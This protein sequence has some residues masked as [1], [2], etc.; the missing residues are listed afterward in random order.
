MREIYRAIKDF[1]TRF[2]Q[3]HNLSLNEGMLLCNLNGRNHTSSEIADILDLS[4]SNT[5]KVIK[6]VEDKGLIERSLGKDDKRQM[7]FSLTPEGRKRLKN[8]QCEC[9]DGT[10][11]DILKSI[12]INKTSSINH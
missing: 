11:D 7:H 3:V 4:A 10:A 1:E 2:Q 9:D 12:H 5:S 6:S 8:I